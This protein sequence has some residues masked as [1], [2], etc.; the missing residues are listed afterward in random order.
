MVDT[1]SS[2]GIPDVTTSE[3]ESTEMEYEATSGNNSEDDN[4]VAYLERLLATNDDPEGDGEDAVYAQDDDGKRS[5]FHTRY[6]INFL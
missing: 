5:T 6:K 4:N 2:A 1:P 3:N